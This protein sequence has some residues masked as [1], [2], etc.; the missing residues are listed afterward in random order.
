ML[1]HHKEPWD[2][3]NDTVVGQVSTSVKKGL[4][5]SHNQPQSS[6]PVKSVKPGEGCL[7]KRKDVHRVQS[8]TL[9]AAAL[10]LLAPKS[11]GLLI[12]KATEGPILPRPSGEVKGLSLLCLFLVPRMLSLIPS[13]TQRSRNPAPL[14]RHYLSFAFQGTVG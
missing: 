7:L 5:C 9:R 10:E 4:K 13:D 1:L 14:Q 11:Q 8:G 2:M 12:K 6:E 3:P